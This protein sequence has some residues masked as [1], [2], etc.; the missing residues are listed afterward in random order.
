MYAAK[1]RSKALKPPIAVFRD[2]DFVC[3]VNGECMTIVPSLSNLRT[4][5]L[6]WWSGILL[7]EAESCY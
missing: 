3:A 1:T 7:F 4:S 5:D 6:F 2:V